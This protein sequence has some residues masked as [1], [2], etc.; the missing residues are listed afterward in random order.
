[1]PE[2]HQSSSQNSQGPHIYSIYLAA[3]AD[4]RR[5][6][7]HKKQHLKIQYQLTSFFF[8][9]LAIAQVVVGAAITALGPSAA[10]HTLAIT[11]LAALSTS[12]AGL[13]A[14]I[15]GRGL[16]QRLRGG[17]I[18]ISKVLDFIQ[19]TTILLKYDKNRVSD[20]GIAPLL[21]E[22]FQR[23][24]SAEQAIE[25]NQPDTFA[26]DFGSQADGDA[27]G[28]EGSPNQEALAHKR[29]GKRR[30]TDEEMGF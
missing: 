19:E 24:A 25:K 5:E 4:L 16:P 11:I 2:P 7:A 23:H 15:K 27:T 6:L 3:T 10:D 21:E 14:L 30:K 29:S 20:D 8:N 18:E 13:L 26:R 12:F 17:M 1:M 9:F 28:V 22:V